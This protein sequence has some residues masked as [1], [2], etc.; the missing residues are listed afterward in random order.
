MK[1][2]YADECVTLWHGDCREI[3]E[4]L[5]A[6]VLV[7]DPPYGIAYIRGGDRK[8]T[9]KQ[10]VIGDADTSLRDRT[11]A[12]WGER[13]AICFGSWRVPKPTGTK[14]TITW[15]KRSV[16][17]GSGDTNLP[18]GNA[19]EEIYILGAGF[20]GV[21]RANVIETWDRRQTASIEIGHPTPKPVGLMEQLIECCPPGVIADPYA[22]SGA[23]L[24]AAR[25]LGRRSIGV[26]VDE[27]FCEIV[28]KRLAQRD[29][30][31]VTA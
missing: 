15:W 23:T 19:T 8:N 5:V 29:L 21:R 2:Y 25:N 16:G 30:F 4:W 12:E 18:W 10:P 28:A 17:P 13:P 31:G 26:E 11:L 3:T 1:P 7:T 27:R 9:P 20:D 14:Q 22:G 6:D 24:I